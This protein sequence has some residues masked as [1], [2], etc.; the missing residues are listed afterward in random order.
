MTSLPLKP[1]CGLSHFKRTRQPWA[2]GK[3]DLHPYFA[4]GNQDTEIRQLA[5]GGRNSLFSSRAELFPLTLTRHLLEYSRTSTIRPR[6]CNDF[7]PTKIKRSKHQFAS[8]FPFFLHGFV[9]TIPWAV[10][11]PQEPALK[12]LREGENG[13]TVN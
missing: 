10:P 7:H 1:S 2:Q 4:R 5:Q 9:C 6:C 8:L 3:Q 12:Q 11:A 13:P